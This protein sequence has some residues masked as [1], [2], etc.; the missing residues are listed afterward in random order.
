MAANL[1]AAH[2]IP[3]GIVAAHWPPVCLAIT[4]ELVALVASPIKQHPIV[5][6]AP[7]AERTADL[8]VDAQPAPRHV[9][10][11]TGLE[12]RAPEAGEAE[13]DT[14]TDNRHRVSEMPGEPAAESRHA[15][16]A[17]PAGTNG[18]LP[19]PV[20]VPTVPSPD[21]RDFSGSTGQ[22]PAPASGH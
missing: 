17:V 2:Q 7:P 10:A 3:A 22:T 18:C 14:G 20:P 6:D 1:A 12:A 4:L 9:P 5:T 15:Q 11:V 16:A 13:H 19:V 21:L 8:P